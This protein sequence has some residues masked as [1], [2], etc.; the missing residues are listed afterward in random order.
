MAYQS[1]EEWFRRVVQIG[2]AMNW[3]VENPEEWRTYYNQG[4]SPEDAFQQEVS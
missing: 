3:H 4:M 1:F 2:Q